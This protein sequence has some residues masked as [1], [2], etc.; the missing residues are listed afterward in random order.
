V[1]TFAAIHAENEVSLQACAAA[2]GT[3]IQPAV[4]VRRGSRLHNLEERDARSQRGAAE[5]R[6]EHERVVRHDSALS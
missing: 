4:R 6:L 5:F 3:H 1:E 2:H